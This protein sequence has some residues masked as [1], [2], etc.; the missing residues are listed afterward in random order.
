MNIV[1]TMIT[2]EKYYER[3]EETNIGALLNRI[4]GL[5][6]FIVNKG[7]ALRIDNIVSI[8]AN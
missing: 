4:S 7:T 6:Y 8:R 3:V 1:I 2:G 5:V